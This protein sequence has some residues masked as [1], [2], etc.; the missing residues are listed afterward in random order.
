MMYAVPV[1]LV[2]LKPIYDRLSGLD[3]ELDALDQKAVKG[4]HGSGRTDAN[5]D[6]TISFPKAFSQVPKVLVQSKDASTRG[7]VLDI[8]N[9]TTTGFQV[10]ARK[11]TGLT[12]GSAGNHSHGY[13]GS[14]AGA[15]DHTHSIAGSIGS[16]T[17]TDM[18]PNSW[19]LESCASGHTT[20]V[21]GAYTSRY[22]ATS[23]HSHFAS[24]P[25]SSAGGHSHGFSGTTGSAGAHAH[26]LDAPALEV[27]FDWVAAGE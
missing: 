9:V 12:T 4:C 10:K 21:I 20:C 27:D 5:G 19:S 7:V 8:Y 3:Q 23:D 14:T 25:T 18:A 22:F 6:A 11:V 17:D 16:P 13:S 1:K 26:S 2:R 15:G 24:A